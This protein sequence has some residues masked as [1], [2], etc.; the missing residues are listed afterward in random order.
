VKTIVRTNQRDL[1]T[2][3][4]PRANLQAKLVSNS[5][6]VQFNL[7]KCFLK[8]CVSE[9]IAIASREGNLYKM[10][11]T[12]VHGVDVADLVQSPTGDGALEL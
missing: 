3:C 4:A 12:K 6:N 5:L 10:Y 11:F 7:S 1:Y 2:R 8:A 9:T